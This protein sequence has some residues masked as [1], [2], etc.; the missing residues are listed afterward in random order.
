GLRELLAERVAA[1]RLY[2]LAVPL[3]ALG[4][5]ASWRQRWALPLI[6]WGLAQAAAYQL[7]GVASYSWYYSPLVP[8]AALLI[9]LG[10]A[11]FG[12]A[13]SDEGRRLSAGRRALLALLLAAPLL[14]A[15]LAGLRALRAAVPEPRALAYER[16]G[17]W[18]A[19][20]TPPD[21]R[22]AVMEVG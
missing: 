13:G 17:E 1:S 5:A 7:L 12:A 14:A 22:V 6:L 9:G 3:G 10:P 11:A 4:L 21:A 20:N 16:A 18:L 15:Q 19:A 2:W 8:A